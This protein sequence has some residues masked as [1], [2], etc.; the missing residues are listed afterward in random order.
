MLNCREVTQLFSEAQERKLGLKEKLSLQVHTMMCSGCRN[1]GS[2]MQ[3]LRQIA[4]T[5]AKGGAGADT[6][7]KK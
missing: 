3:I 2:Q 7:Q 6:K 5:Y 1:F 4:R